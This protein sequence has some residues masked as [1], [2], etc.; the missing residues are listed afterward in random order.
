MSSSCVFFFLSK[1]K[2]SQTKFHPVGELNILMHQKAFFFP[3]NLETQ[4]FHYEYFQQVAMHFDIKFD[5]F[6]ERPL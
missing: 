5:V 4:L 2:K 3:T 6:V 1:T